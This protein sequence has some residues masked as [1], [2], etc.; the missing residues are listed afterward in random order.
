[1]FSVIIPLYNKASH[2]EK[3]ILS[4]AAQTFN[5]FEMIII[6]DGSTD[7][8]FSK[9]KEITQS[10]SSSIKS[11]RV[12]TQKN[13]GVSTTRNTG[14]KLA[15]YDYIAFLDADDWWAP[16]YL[17][18][19]K[20]LVEKYPEAG[21][22]ASS[23]Y[24]VKYGKTI[25]AGIGVDESFQDGVINYFQ[26]YA[27]TLWMPIWTGA[28]IIN[29]DVFEKLNGFNPMLKLGEDFDLW[30]RIAANYP[31]AFLNKPLAYY[32][33]DVDVNERAVG[34]RLYK[35]HEHMLF[36]T[37]NQKLISNSDFLF[38]YERLA[39]YGLLPYYLKGENQEETMKILL[40]IHWKWH[41]T[42][43]KLYYKILPVNILR[44]W[45]GL[46]LLISKIRRKVMIC[47]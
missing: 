26:V 21:I 29:K 33:Q 7:E 2:I 13:C 10:L 9:A 38:L 45:F 27:K 34:V 35:P 43:Y 37:Y 36:S 32:N 30:A 12:L 15:K 16:D 40:S 23:Y 17:E 3:A 20:L 6:D 24:K 11:W 14:V 41:E 22:F 42:K 4:I 18:S 25:P 47:I 46:K 28:T 5:N 1:M 8:S 31:V 39:L 44:I 19:M